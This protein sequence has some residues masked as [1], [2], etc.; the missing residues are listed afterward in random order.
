M[1]AMITV[2]MS[3]V[4]GV[5]PVVMIVVMIMFSHGHDVDGLAVPLNL[6]SR[7]GYIAL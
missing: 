4:V 5:S 3:T 6:S 2:A 1:V 7:V